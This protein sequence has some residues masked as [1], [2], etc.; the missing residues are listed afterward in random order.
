MKK[1]WICRWVVTP[2]NGLE[3]QVFASLAEAKQAMR[4]KIA[5]TID[6]KKYLSYLQPDVAA[7][8]GKYLSDPQFPQSKEDMPEEYDDPDCDELIL[9]TSFI[10]WDYMYGAAP[11]MNTNLVLD[12]ND[13][14]EYTFDFWYECP[15]KVTGNG[16]KSLSI[17]I[18]SYMD[19]GTSAYPLMVL[20]ALREH[21]QTQEQIIRTISTTWGAVL[22][23]KSV[24]RHLHLLENLGYPVQTCPE[25]YFRGGEKREP[26]TDIKYTACAYPLLILHVLDDTPKT[27][28]A[29]IQTVL[30]QFGAKID[31]KAVG[32]HLEL[33]EALGI[34]VKSC[35]DGY[36]IGK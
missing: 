29:I 12:D 17:S 36:Y 22:N 33:L 5:E 8:L 21:P 3:T 18:V 7:V 9:E 2:G 10:R 11:R 4:Q 30:E 1:G 16:I 14:E 34:Y 27:K 15:E 28:A 26:Q 13:E 32:R 23:R 25:G 20:F 19:Y 31:R 24:G 6:L 35:E